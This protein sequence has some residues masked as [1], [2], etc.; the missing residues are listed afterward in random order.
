[1]KDF[2]WNF[3]IVWVSLSVVVSNNKMFDCNSTANPYRKDFL[4]LSLVLWIDDDIS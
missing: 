1:M 4:Q 2:Q 3:I